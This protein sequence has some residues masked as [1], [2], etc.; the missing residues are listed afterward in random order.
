MQT[1]VKVPVDQSSQCQVI[2]PPVQCNADLQLAFA[3][4]RDHAAQLKSV[5]ASMATSSQQQNLQMLQAKMNVGASVTQLKTQQNSVHQSLSAGSI[6]AI[7]YME[8]EDLSQG[9]FEVGSGPAAQLTAV[10]PSKPGSTGLPDNLKAGIENLSGISMDHVRV[11]YNSEKPAQLNAHAYAQGSDI[12]VAAG[13]GK[14]LPHEAWHVVQQAQ[15]RVKPTVQMKGNLLVNDDAGFEGEA[16]VMG[17]RALQFGDA[18]LQ[19]RNGAAVMQRKLCATEGAGTTVAQR[20]V[21]TV[22]EDGL[23]SDSAQIVANLSGAKAGAFSEVEPTETIYI[24]AHGYHSLTRPLTREERTT[25]LEPILQGGITAADLCGMMIQEGWSEEHT[26][27]IDIRA[28]MSGAESLL[29]SFAELFAGELKKLGRMNKVTGYKHLTSTTSDGV[30]K[31]M[32]PTISKMV[33]VAQQFDPEDMEHE[34]FA[35]DVTSLFESKNDKILQQRESCNKWKG[36]AKTMPAMF[37]GS[38][39]QGSGMSNEEW[40]VYSFY[41]AVQNKNQD[42]IDALKGAFKAKSYQINKPVGGAHGRQFDPTVM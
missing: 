34:F 22:N 39:P 38:P 31:A 20:A 27:D 42:L 7:Q 14:H 29:P 9:E 32:K 25:N 24:F 36:Y 6:S 8:D 12:H 1:K 23:I 17:A 33:D 35:I 26:G 5:Q 3:D 4:H 30:E 2:Q 11:H 19:S 41:Y 18:M 40:N 13:Q 37:I 10:M 15:G 16:D 28:C 21:I